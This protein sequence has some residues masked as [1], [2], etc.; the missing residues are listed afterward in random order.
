MTEDQKKQFAPIL[1]EE[2]SQLQALKKDESLD[3][4]KK[5]ERLRAIGSSFDAKMTPLLNA[6]QQKKF[7]AF[8]EQTRRQIVAALKQ[9]ILAMFKKANEREELQPAEKPAD[10]L[11]G[12]VE[13]R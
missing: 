1:K 11:K 7:Q 6:E 9:K 5:V 3:A 13:N 10:P 8:R 4:L 2:L 12:D